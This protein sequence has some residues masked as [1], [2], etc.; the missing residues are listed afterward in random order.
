MNDELDHLLSHSLAAS[1]AQLAPAAAVGDLAGVTRRHRRRSAARLAAGVTTAGVLAAGLFALAITRPHS[2]DVVAQS[3]PSITSSAALADTAAPAPTSPC[4]DGQVSTG[5]GDVLIHAGRPYPVDAG[6]CVAVG[7]LAEGTAAFPMPNVGGY[8]CK[9]LVASGEGT[10][11]PSATV[12]VDIPPNTGPSGSCPLAEMG[13]HVFD[14]AAP[15]ATD[16][17]A[18]CTLA[19]VACHVLDGVPV[20]DGTVPAGVDPTPCPA[21]V[22]VCQAVNGLPIPV[23]PGHSAPDG[24][25]P[26]GLPDLSLP[27]FDPAKAGA[28]FGCPAPGS[29]P[30]TTPTVA[31]TTMP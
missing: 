24:T 7:A 6:Q 20:P 11:G 2:A 28:V 26:A 14:S 30:T 16:N 1:A 15:A 27:A 9:L 23:G 12:V 19:E 4:G 10:S 29:D 17:P 21:V 25:F 8:Q 13:C 5:Q 18:P 31:P 22:M 3:A